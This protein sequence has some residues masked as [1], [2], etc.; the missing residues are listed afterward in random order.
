M[1]SSRGSS[2]DRS[3]LSV[4]RFL[5]QFDP[6]VPA[7]PPRRVSPTEDIHAEQGYQ[8]TAPAGD[9]VD[10]GGHPPQVAEDP[11]VANL[12]LPLA[13]TG[14]LSRL[15]GPT[16]QSATTQGRANQLPAFAPG[17]HSVDLGGGPPQVAEDPNLASRRQQ[18]SLADHRASLQRHGMQPTDTALGETEL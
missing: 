1:A 11:N 13:P 15:G 9:S 5:D 12:F 8:T 6:A 7:V 14:D 4:G 10:L 18:L 16:T 17:G 2:P 3:A